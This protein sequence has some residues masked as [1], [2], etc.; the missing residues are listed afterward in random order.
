MADIA[1][2][3]ERLGQEQA[4]L[5]ASKAELQ[6]ALDQYNQAV[7]N[8]TVTPGTQDALRLR[9]TLGIASLQADV[10]TLQTAVDEVTN[11]LTSAEQTIGNEPRTS[12]GQTVAQGQRANDE[13]ANAVAPPADPAAAPAITNADRFDETPN[14]DSN[15]NADARSLTD[16][17]SLP[18]ITARPGA[19]PGRITPPNSPGQTVPAG[20]TQPDLGTGGV[21]SDDGA[22]NQPTRQ[23][24]VGASSD[25][26]TGATNSGVRA[27]LNQRFAGNI[28]PQGN[29]L[30]QYASYT[31]SISIYLMSAT[32]YRQFI[33]SPN[34]LPGGSQL[35]LQSG[36]APA[37][38][39]LVAV[40]QADTI[41]VAGSSVAIEDPGQV[42]A[43]QVAKS[44]LTRNPFF[45]LDYY[46]DDVRLESA[47]SGKGVGQAHNVTKLQFRVI[48]PN[49]ITFLDNLYRATDQ[50]VR[51][52]G[53]AQT[54]YAAQNYL[55]VIRFYGYDRDGNLVLSQNQPFLDPISRKRIDTVVEKFIPFQINAI[56][57]RVANK[58]AEYD[59]ECAAVRTSVAASAARGTIPYNVELT[60]QTLKDLLGG[61]AQFA[62]APVDTQGR[63]GATPA[64]DPKARNPA[65]AGFLNTNE[66]GVGTDFTLGVGA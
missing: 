39:G 30:D 56:K 19:A 18:P 4:R 9:R 44:N 1:G 27:A 58:M 25:D 49:G 41:S 24:G 57:F 37:G 17:Q 26:Q 46:L 5:A 7:S 31:Y 21:V 61:Q 13:G 64:V 36:G 59:V 29:V 66:S 22:S 42:L 63:P 40:N 32:D 65:N 51:L 16:T 38:G 47:M 50:Y 45:S 34:A 2:I 35:L 12:A 62:K 28:I 60:S 55:M 3:R 11:E 23:A 54:N 52:S 10:E 8:G 6:Q 20:S 53:S 33:T 48:E 43:N 14:T 15:T